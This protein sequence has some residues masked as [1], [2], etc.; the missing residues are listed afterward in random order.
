MY[1]VWDNSNIHYAG[2]DQVMPIKEPDTQ[3][4]LYRTYF[5][6]VLDLARNGRKVDDIYFCGSN[7]PKEGDSLWTAVSALGIDPI[8]IPRSLTE[9]EADATDRELQLAILHLYFDHP[10]A[11]TV[12]LLTGDGAGIK[13]GKGFL[14]EA[15]RLFDRGWKFEVYS[16]DIACHGQL[17]EF[18][19][20][21]GKYY[22]LED[23]YENITFIKNGR[24]PVSLI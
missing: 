4:E 5:Q 22:K 17:R 16:W 8:I 13:Q 21:H 19:E 1:I 7:P 14:A 11:D 6:G 3:R 10:D 12:A 20:T 2:L 18:A 24:K 23:Y 15:K 9:G